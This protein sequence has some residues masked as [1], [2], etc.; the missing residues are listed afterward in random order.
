MNNSVD[1]KDENG[2][3][4]DEE[5]PWYGGGGGGCG[6]GGGI[7]GGAGGGGAHNKSGNQ[8]ITVGKRSLFGRGRRIGL[9][10]YDSSSDEAEEEEDEEEIPTKKSAI[11]RGG[12]SRRA[13]DLLLMKIGYKGFYPLGVFILLFY[14]NAIG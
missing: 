6:A 14:A 12:V 1:E 11:L 3:N 13:L 2:E 10:K 8:R 5:L 7:G 9:K 4:N